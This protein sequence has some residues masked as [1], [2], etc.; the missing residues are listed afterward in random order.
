MLALVSGRRINRR[1]AVP[2]R[3]VHPIWEPGDVVGLDQQ[4]GSSGLP[5][6]P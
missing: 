3:E 2:G 6:A 5:D 4:P 1:G